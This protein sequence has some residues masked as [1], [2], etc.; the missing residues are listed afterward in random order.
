[1]PRPRLTCVLSGGGAKAAAHVGALKALE[2]HGLFVSRFVATSM[3]AVIAACFASGLPYAEVLRRLLLVRRRGVASPSP[4]LLL[5]PFV[6]SLFRGRPLYDTIADLVPARRFSE[7]DV[8]LTVTA[9]DVETGQ[10]TLFGSGGAT[11][12]PLVEALYATCAL[13]VYYPPAKIGGRWYADGGLR[14]VLPLDVAAEFDP[15]FVF[16]V[17]VGP[18]FDAPPAAR[19]AP[20]PPLF[21]AHTQAMRILMASETERVIR[22]FRA[23]TTPLVLVRPAFERDATFALENVVRYVEHGYRTAYRALARHAAAVTGGAPEEAGRRT[24]GPADGRSS[25]S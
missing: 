3:G 11:E 6:R 12:V 4:S 18:A 20:L 15:D 14:T 2:D 19:R 24:G 10:L 7:L 13:P 1:M 8:P 5:G 17:D 16:A 21:R 25:D 22:Q 23:G 9:V